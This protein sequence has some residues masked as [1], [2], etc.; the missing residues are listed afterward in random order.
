MSGQRVCERAH[1]SSRAVGARASWG[2]RREKKEEDRGV[3]CRRHRGT[4]SGALGRPE[5]AGG[6]LKGVATLQVCTVA[7]SGA[8]QLHARAC[9]WLVES[10]HLCLGC[11]GRSKQR[12][13]GLGC[14]GQPVGEERG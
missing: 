12:G 10:G 8:R 13:E 9:L 7:R 4:S 6:G 14:P 5:V 2:E 3:A 1:W 11:L